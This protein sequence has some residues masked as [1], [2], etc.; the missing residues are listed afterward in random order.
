MLSVV[1]KRTAAVIVLSGSLL[2]GASV[3]P[4]AATPAQEALYLAAMKDAWKA[5]P[6]ASQKTTCVAYQLAPHK[7]V[8]QSLARILK[9]PESQAAL[10]KP[11]WRRVV[12]K[13]VA[14]ACSG[15]GS[16]PR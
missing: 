8:N 9:N 15:P 11:A 14:W 7:L 4:A 2:A 10:S 6:S 3:V 5:L 12:T 13:Y 16:T 1:A